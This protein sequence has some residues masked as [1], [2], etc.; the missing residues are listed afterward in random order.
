V[1]NEANESNGAAD[2]KDPERIPAWFRDPDI[3]D[4]PVERVDLVETHISWV[5]LTGEYAYKVKKPVSLPFVDFSTLEQRRASCEDEV[6]L[7]RRLAP[8]L[9][10]GVVALGGTPEAPRIGAEPALEYAVK[11][12]QF[13]AEARL[14]NRIAAGSVGVGH[15]QAFAET[16][17]AFHASLPPRRA[18]ARDGTPEIDAFAENLAE[19]EQALDRDERVSADIRD[20][21]HTHRATLDERLARRA[22]DGFVRECHGDLHLENLV[23]LDDAVVAFDAL[24]FSEKLRT[25]DLIDEVGFLVMDCGAHGR[26]DLGYAFLSRYLEITGDYPGLGVLAFYRLHRALVRA[27]V[28]AIRERQS[29]GHGAARPYLREAGRIVE[30]RRPRLVLMRGLSG[31]GKTYVARS[32]VPRLPAVSVR[33][34]L[35]RKRLFGLAANAETGSD[36]AA[37]IY[38]S[39]AGARTYRA[40]EQSAASA[41]DAGIDVIVDAA[42]LARAQ[43][44]IFA[45]LARTSGA[46]FLIVDCQAP[47]AVLRE[48]ISARKAEARDASEATGAVLDYQL[49]TAEPLD[50][51]ELTR[52]LTL[53]T[54]GPLDADALVARIRAGKI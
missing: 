38:S 36:V 18:R 30:P 51:D 22:E 25:I 19:L 2:A 37:G 31:S 4:H 16:V 14:D 9:Y 8:S 40:V 43:R 27:K 42:S 46:E 17:A 15:L 32:L 12:R 29:G 21:L 44:A 23:L 47:E 33:S 35:E 39:E 5:F 6:R 48:R 45:A 13:S 10:L 53:D 26:E 20:W 50:G 28:R 34:D 1:T 54:S 3:Y 11:M 52:T 49:T 24:E 7:N 41:L